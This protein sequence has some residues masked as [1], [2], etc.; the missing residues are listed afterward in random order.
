MS[1]LRSYVRSASSAGWVLS[2][3]FL[4]GCGG[5]TGAAL[6]VTG[7]S[8]A[9]AASTI[10]AGASSGFNPGAIGSLAGSMLPPD[11]GPGTAMSTDAGGPVVTPQ[12][13]DGCS[14]LCTKEGAANCSAFGSV[15]SCML[16]CELL[17]RNPAC[18]SDAQNLF[19]CVGGGATASCDS[20]GNATFAS[21]GLQELASGSCFLVNATDQSLGA[22]CTTY[23]SAVA[24]AKCPSDSPNGCVD[25]CQIL[26]NLFGCDS[27]WTQYVVCANGSTLSCGSDGKAGASAC[28]TQAAAFWECAASSLVTLTVDGG[29]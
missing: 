5:T 19:S 21:C 22:P 12:V 17:V 13:V 20:S 2:I 28:V 29:S 1:D 24:A 11:A 9:E 14:Q 8:G 15:S 26:G 16:G 23:C 25:S 7:D 6:D 18:S 27:A 4:A 10:E 3:A